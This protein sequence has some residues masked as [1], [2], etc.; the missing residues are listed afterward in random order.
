MTCFDRFGSGRPDVHQRARWPKRSE[1]LCGLVGRGRQKAARR[2][3][4]RSAD[5]AHLPVRRADLGLMRRNHCEAELG[6]R[7]DTCAIIGPDARP[8][9]TLGLLRAGP[10]PARYDDIVSAQPAGRQDPLNPARGAPDS[11]VQR[12]RTGYRQ[13]G[14]IA[15]I[16]NGR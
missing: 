12:R 9:T 14:A 16:V 11:A 15:R 7:C 6:D 1:Y 4:V 3:A 8:G 10:D 5:Y 2:A 13:L